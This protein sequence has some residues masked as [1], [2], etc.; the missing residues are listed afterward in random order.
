MKNLLFERPEPLKPSHVQILRYFTHLGTPGGASR[1]MLPKPRFFT[2]FVDRAPPSFL[3]FFY[4]KSIAPENHAWKWYVFFRIILL[5]W[6]RCYNYTCFYAKVSI[7]HV[8]I[9][10]CLRTCSFLTLFHA[11]RDM[12][13]Q[14]F[15]PRDEAMFKSIGKTS[16]KIP[17]WNSGY[18]FKFDVFKALRFHTLFVARNAFF[19]NLI[20]LQICHVTIFSI[21]IGKINS[22]GRRK[23][24]SSLRPKADKTQREP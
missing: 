10:S 23:H 21:F 8:F 6:Q 3:S 5:F 7:W 18:I 2:H 12:K 14:G 22:P 15:R 17:A 11:N 1:A 20:F 16:K 9:M 13:D 19:Q 24:P 4:A